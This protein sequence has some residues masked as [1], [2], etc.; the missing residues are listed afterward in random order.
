MKKIGLLFLA[1]VLTTTISFSQVVGDKAPDF[2][3]DKLGGG[4]G[5]L[6]DYSGKVVMVFIFGYSCPNCIGAASSIKSN[7]LSQF[8]SNPNFV[9]IGI[10]AWNGSA[11]QV[12]NF[13]NSTGFDFPM[14][15]KGSGTASSWSSSYDRLLVIGADGKFVYKGNSL[16]INSVSQ[17]KS[18]VLEALSDVSTSLSRAEQKILTQ[19][20]PNPFS[21][22]TTIA[23]KLEKAALVQIDIIDISGK[24][25][26]ELVSGQYSAGEQEVQF[27]R[28]G[29]KSGVYFYSIKAGDKIDTRRMQIQ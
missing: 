19:N 4:K 12:Q 3:L 11:S 18:A 6:S 29:L 13:K 26:R 28:D 1:M 25:V 24:K 16:A 8:Q 9:A 22:T 21:H 2:N 27:N 5:S 17:T 15:L 10:D 14:F 20:Y 7:L 23:F